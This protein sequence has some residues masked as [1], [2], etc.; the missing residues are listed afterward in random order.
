M[1]GSAETPKF[2][3]SRLAGRHG[4]LIKVTFG[5]EEPPVQLFFTKFHLDQCISMGTSSPESVNFDNFGEYRRPWGI[6]VGD[7]DDFL[8][9]RL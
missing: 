7:T 1:I 9:D 4:A 8:G 5:I 2:A 3:L 6:L